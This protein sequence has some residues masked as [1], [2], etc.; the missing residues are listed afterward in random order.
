MRI[1]KEEKLLKS[2]SFNSL[3]CLL[4]AA[5]KCRETEDLEIPKWS[6]K[7]SSAPSYSLQEIPFKAFSKRSSENLSYYLVPDIQRVGLPLIPSA[8]VAFSLLFFLLPHKQN[9]L[10]SFFSDPAVD[11]IQVGKHFSF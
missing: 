4:V 3:S 8:N 10:G 11:R 2:L 7:P 9:P 6:S 1:A 5:F